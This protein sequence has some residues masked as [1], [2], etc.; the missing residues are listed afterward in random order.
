[1]AISVRT[2]TWDD[3]EDMLRIEKETM[4]THTYLFETQKELMDP[5]Q[6]WM[7]ISFDD[8]KPIGIAHLYRQPDGAGWF[9]ILRVTPAEQKKGAGT[10]MWDRAIELCE[11]NGLKS[12]AM[13]T[14]LKNV[15]SRKI[16][17]RKGL[18]LRLAVK[19]GELSRE[20]A[21]ASFAGSAPEAAACADGAAFAAACEKFGAEE[22]FGGQ[23][24]FN[25]TFYDFTPENLAWLCGEGIAYCGGDFAAA[26]GARFNKEAALQIGFIAGDEDKA[27]EL[28]V[29][30]LLAG[31][32]PKLVIDVPE[33]RTDLIEKLKGK[34]F[35]FI[36][37]T[38]ITLK[39][40]FGK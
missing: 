24:V 39:R 6:G 20:A 26:I 21:I 10:A 9:E 37:S 7:L 30:L 38:I 23:F 5:E 3:L 33:E 22:A 11:E 15:T 8:D 1:M 2:A 27:V 17:E 35:S 4:P 19:E 31:P 40:V 34:G 25:R 14:G 18:S 36:D 13:Y 29:K 12:I 28:A 16:A 32:W